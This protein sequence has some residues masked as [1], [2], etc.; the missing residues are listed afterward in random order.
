MTGTQLAA[1]IRKKTRTN[2]TTFTDADM[3]VDVNIFKDEIASMIVERNAKY[4]LI[5][6]KFDLVADQRE[7]TFDDNL[8]NRIEKVE[9]KFS[10]STSRFPA[11]FLKD[12]YGSETE[13]EIVKK[14]SNA[15]GGFAYIIRRRGIFILSGTIINVTDG[16]R[17]IWSKYPSN[18]SD[19]TGST[20]LAI[21]PSTTTFGFPRQF[22]ELLARRVSME[23]K[24]RQPK[25]I[26]FN[27]ME[28]NYDRDLEVQLAAI[29]TIDN[30]AEVIGE[31]PDAADIGNDG[32]DY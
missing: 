22:H 17:M 3:L 30:S 1:L 32:W 12:Y 16:G 28:K 8:L 31:L 7:Y 13:S 9:I 26:P 23:Y 25:P 18:L 20:D 19:L 14:Y 21:D 6:S 4:F 24:G 15:E 5:P 27:Q 10:S 29:S 2:S 11:R